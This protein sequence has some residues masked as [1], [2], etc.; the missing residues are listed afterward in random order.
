MYFVTVTVL[1][2][3][4][5]ALNI[6]EVMIVWILLLDLFPVGEYELANHAKPVHHALVG[7]SLV[8]KTIAQT[9]RN[10]P[11]PTT[12]LVHPLTTHNLNKAKSI[13]G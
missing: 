1:Y 10:L 3:L 4:L 7:A 11:T 9:R 13:R 2:L 5:G 8:A 6:I 12:A